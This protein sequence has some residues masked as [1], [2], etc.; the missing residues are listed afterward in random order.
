[1]LSNTSISM[2]YHHI[3][4]TSSVLVF[5]LF[6]NRDGS[7]HKEVVNYRINKVGRGRN[8]NC[9]TT[10]CTMNDEMAYVSTPMDDESSFTNDFYHSNHSTYSNPN[11]QHHR[12]YSSSG[13]N[14]RLRQSNTNTGNTR[15]QSNTVVTSSS[16]K[17][18]HNEYDI[19]EQPQSS[20][21][22]STFR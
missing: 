4:L 11:N 20:S 2:N 1:M 5:N 15:R 8:S 7:R 22:S 17:K 9:N 6:F 13:P 21:G 19:D 3:T 16:T 12:H 18:R 10:T 14:L